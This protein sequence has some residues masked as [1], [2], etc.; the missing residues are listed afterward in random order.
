[1]DDK[2]PTLAQ[3]SHFER[4]FWPLYQ[5]S[6]ATMG[7]MAR[8]FSLQ[9]ARAV[10]IGAGLCAEEIALA[11][12]GVDV[13][14]IEPAAERV[15]FARE[16]AAELG[17]ELQFRTV[18]IRDFADDAG[19]DFI[20]TSC[21]DDWT[22]GSLAAAVPDDYLR[23]LARFSRPGA[24]FVAKLW[25]YEYTRD[26][27]STDWFACAVAERLRRHTPFRLREQ[28]VTQSGLPT[29]L[30][31]ARERADL[32]PADGFENWAARFNDPGRLKVAY[33]EDEVVA[34][35]VAQRLVPYGLRLRHVARDVRNAVRRRVKTRRV[36]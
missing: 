16:K 32:G 14:C 21:P 7:D 24:V 19:F 33:A 27:T 31:A 34:P 36:V 5:A 6:Q 8:R 1:M 29:M 20:Y 10:S 25:S 4:W 9:G 22:Q 13:T 28:W 18:G 26:V 35:S 11:K 3:R 17:Q 23:L 30:V 12:A 2:A 15:S